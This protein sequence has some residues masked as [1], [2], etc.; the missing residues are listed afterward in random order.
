MSTT[1]SLAECREA[2]RSG[3]VG[4][5]SAAVCLTEME[6]LAPRLSPAHPAS[7]PAPTDD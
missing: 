6:R 1:P 7:G 3:Q 2:V 4:V 5:A